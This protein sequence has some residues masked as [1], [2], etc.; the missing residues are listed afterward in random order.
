MLEYSFQKR[1]LLLQ[2][3]NKPY[4]LVEGVIDYDVSSIPCDWVSH[5]SW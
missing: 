4:V 1:Q 2:L 3:H 5:T